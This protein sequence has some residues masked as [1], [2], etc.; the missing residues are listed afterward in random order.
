M[1]STAQLRGASQAVSSLAHHPH[2]HRYRCGCIPVRSR[3]AGARA[4]CSCGETTDRA[5]RYGSP[6][7]HGFRCAHD[8]DDRSLAASAAAVPAALTHSYTMHSPTRVIGILGTHT[9]VGKTWVL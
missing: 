1:R 6:A 5:A 3:F 9:E 2:H 4:V 8:R 7:R